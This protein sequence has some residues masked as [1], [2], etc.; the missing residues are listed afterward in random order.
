MGVDNHL[1]TTTFSPVGELRV[2]VAYNVTRSVAINA[3]YTGLVVGNISRASNSI[4]YDAVNLVGIHLNDN[5]IFFA[6][7]L[8][9]GVSINR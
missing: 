5:Q 3:G 1:Y 6:N 4:N 9:F 2:N 7:G 8:N